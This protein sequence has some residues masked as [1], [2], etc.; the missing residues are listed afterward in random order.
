V[1]ENYDREVVDKRVSGQIDLELSDS[2]FMVGALKEL[3]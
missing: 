3:I 1:V 2:K